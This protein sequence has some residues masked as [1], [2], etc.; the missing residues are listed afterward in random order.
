MVVAPSVQAAR[1]DVIP[2]RHTTERP[3]EHYQLIELIRDDLGGFTVGL[4]IKL[5]GGA[6]YYG[7]TVRINRA[8]FPSFS[9]A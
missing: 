9:E 5:I 3:C 7:R 6:S 8:A 1:D 4:S 2:S